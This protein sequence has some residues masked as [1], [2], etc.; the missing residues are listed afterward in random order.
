MAQTV[1]EIVIQLGT[2]V[3]EVA[4][5]EAAEIGADKTF[6]DDLGI[7][8]LSMVEILYGIEDSFDLKIPEEEGNNFRTVGDAAAYIEKALIEKEEQEKAAAGTGQA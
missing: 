8:S 7:D 1:E 6:G 3:N 2:I 4:G 5:I